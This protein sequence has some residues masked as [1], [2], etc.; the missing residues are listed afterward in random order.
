MDLTFQSEYNEDRSARVIGRAWT[1]RTRGAIILSWCMGIAG[2]IW[3]FG[4]VMDVNPKGDLFWCFFLL[5]YSFFAGLWRRLVVR[6]YRKAWR[7]Q[8]GS[9]K[10]VNLHL[11]DDF[12]E[13]SFG[14]SL[15]KMPWRTVATSYLFMDDAVVLFLHKSPRLVVDGADLRAGNVNRAEF[16]AVLRNAGMKSIYELRTRKVGIFLSWLFGLLIILSAVPRVCSAISTRVLDIRTTQVQAR[17]F[18]EVHGTMTNCPYVV[19]ASWPFRL[20]S[21]FLKT[22]EPDECLYIFDDEEEEDKVGIF[23]RY[24]KR[25]Y[26]AYF[27][28]GCACEQLS[29][30]FDHIKELHKPTVFLEAEKE[31][32]LEKVRP[33]AKD[34]Y[35]PEDEEDGEACEESVLT[36]TVDAKTIEE[37]TV[38]VVKAMKQLHVREFEAKAGEEIAQVVARLHELAK[39]GLPGLPSERS[40]ISIL[41]KSLAQERERAEV[42]RK[43]FRVEDVSFYDVVGAF[44]AVADYEFKVDGGYL[45]IAPTGTGFPDID[46]ACL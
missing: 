8:M 43:G 36:S 24:G 27:P 31:K 28:C 5:F 19:E 25:S 23:A 21:S 11:T 46:R 40:G 6:W 30:S 10:V 13:C 26:E 12:Y 17:L 22:T 4:H 15:S 41:L 33:I 37:R 3:L 1:I 18:R 20:V 32:W 7:T 29:G 39:P 42:L 45:R 16:E 9:A 35:V 14:E 38:A 44:C 34:L 2:L